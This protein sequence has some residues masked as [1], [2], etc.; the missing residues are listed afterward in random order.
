LE[1]RST[2]KKSTTTPLVFSPDQN[3]DGI[4][5]SWSSFTLRV[6]TPEQFVRVFASTASAQTWVVQPEGCAWTNS[7]SC[8]DARGGTFDIS[9]STSWDPIGN[10]SLWTEEDLGYTGAAEYGYETVGLGGEGDGGPTIKNTTVGAYYT[11]DFYLGFL[12]LNPK[13]TNFT[14]FT[15]E[16]P[17]YMTKLKEEGLIPSLSYGYTAGNE[18][19]R[20]KVLA[21]LTLGGYDDSRHITNEHSFSFAPDNERDLVVGLQGATMN[22]PDGNSVDLL[23]TPVLMYIDSTVPQIWLPLDACQ[24]FEEAFGLT[25]DEATDL[26]LVD[27][28]TYES[29]RA[30]D[31]NVT[32]VL[33]DDTSGGDTINITLAYSAFDL[34]AKSP[35]QGLANSSRYF[36]LRRAQNESQYVFGRTFLQETYLIVDYERQNFSVSE[37]SFL[38]DTQATIRAILPPDYD[39]SSDDDGGDGSGTSPINAGAIAGIA[40]GCFVAVIAVASFL[41]LLFWRRRYRKLAAQLKSQRSEVQNS[42]PSMAMASEAELDGSNGNSHGSWQRTTASTTPYAASE[43]DAS[44][45]QIFEMPGD[46]PPLS[47][48]DGHQLSEKQA[49]MH[50]ERKYNG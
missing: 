37:C 39:G 14:S 5:G 23:P 29:I 32:F 34:T 2:S 12:G 11:L 27:E 31:P 49:M 22:T 25:Y 9:N 13:G 17:S 26:Y 30:M 28:T 8:P 48:A 19:R 38:S 36:P 46:L 45:T 4:D 47:E 16:S 40:I 44:A 10:F 41:G 43:V 18:Y 15:E 7:S 1:R 3:W 33:G 42:R 50:R 35:Y 6:G 21:S 20:T 24:Q